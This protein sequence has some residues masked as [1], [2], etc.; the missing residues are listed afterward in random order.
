MGIT[1]SFVTHACVLWLAAFDTDDLV[2]AE[3][4]E[5]H[6]KRLAEE[7]MPMYGILRFW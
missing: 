4:P 7:P 1:V 6:G 3:M 5:N 2:L